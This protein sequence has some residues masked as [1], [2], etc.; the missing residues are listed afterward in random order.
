MAASWAM[1]A[2]KHPRTPHLPWSPGF[3]GDDIR[4]ADA[5]WLCGTEVIVTEKMDGE[6]TSLYGCPSG[7]HARS[8]DSRHHPSQ[9]W[10]K[11]LHSLIWKDIPAG[12][13]VCSE[14][15]F[16]KHSI[17]YI[18]LPSYFLM[19]SIWNDKNECLSYDETVEWAELLGLSMVPLIWRGQWPHTGSKVDKAPTAAELIKSL[20][21]KDTS[22][23]E[24][25]VVRRASKFSFSEFAT[26]MAKWVRPGHVQTDEHWKEQ[27]IVPN[28]ITAI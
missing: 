10:C 26:S 25:Y 21:P 14:N 20:E 6:N 13:R 5:S 15:L 16:A 2:V 23:H 19:F 17:H 24:G 27:A 12:W 3:S 18:S 4:L 11:H 28:G 1:N 7:Y 8:L 9:S 22:L